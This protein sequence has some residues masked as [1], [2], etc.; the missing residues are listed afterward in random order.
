MTRLSNIRQLI[1]H[2]WATKNRFKSL[3]QKVSR[4]I[5]VGLS[6]KEHQA[7]VKTIAQPQTRQILRI[8]PQVVFRYTAPYLSENIPLTRRRDMLKGHYAF[9]NDVFNADFF[10][11]VLDK[12]LCLWGALIEGKFLSIQLSG[13]CLITKNREGDL[14]AT[15]EYDGRIACK[16]GFSIVP[17]S[18]LP[19][20]PANNQITASHILFIGRSPRWQ[21]S[22]RA[23]QT[24]GLICSA[25][26][27]A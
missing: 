3:L 7:L 9:L 4:L 1:S 26:H 24:G 20:L 23:Q 18:T 6:F 14:T 17:I 5:I 8:F 25:P 22:R 21:Q 13:P 11:A 2:Q 27:A 10:P 12:S 19:Q 15:V 16:I